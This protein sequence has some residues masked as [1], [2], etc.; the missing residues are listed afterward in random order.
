MALATS[1]TVLC[2]TMQG[3]SS[4]LKTRLS[5]TIIRLKLKL[6]GRHE[7][8]FTRSF[9]LIKR[10]RPIWLELSKQKLWR[11]VMLTKNGTRVSSER[12]AL[13]RLSIK[14]AVSDRGTAMMPDS[15]ARSSIWLMRRTQTFVLTLGIS[16]AMRNTM[17][18]SA[19][20]SADQ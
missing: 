7:K 3:L 6:Q 19:A 4:L 20:R 15:L 9:K 1:A 18:L 12:L 13:M 5:L 8:R 16:A 2:L 14:M 11:Q 17:L 10:E